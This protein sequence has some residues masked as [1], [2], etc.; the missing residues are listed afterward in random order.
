[1]TPVAGGVPDTQDDRDVPTS[2][3]LERFGSP[4]PPINGIF[5]VLKQVGAGRGGEPVHHAITPPDAT[6]LSG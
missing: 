4:G 6:R 1:M 2:C 3:F 5:R